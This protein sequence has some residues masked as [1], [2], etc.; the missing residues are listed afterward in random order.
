[1]V[2]RPVTDAVLW[3]V[4]QKLL[5]LAD[6]R[7]GMA[8]I[9]RTEMGAARPLLSVFSLAIES[10]CVG[11]TVWQGGCAAKRAARDYAAL[12]TGWSLGRSP[13]GMPAARAVTSHRTP[14]PGSHLLV[15]VSIC[16]W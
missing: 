8:D 7:Q 1:M 4:V 11:G 3:E 5:S 12:L 16:G 14:N 15:S 9:T 13:A 6:V 10:S 2:N